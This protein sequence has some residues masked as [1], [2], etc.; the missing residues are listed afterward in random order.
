MVEI[1]KRNVY[2]RRNE[3][4]K[5]GCGNY[6]FPS[7]EKYIELVARRDLYKLLDEGLED[8]ANGRTQEF[9]VAMKEIRKH[10]ADGGK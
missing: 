8:I 9:S 4:A 2:R 5:H 10:I 6:I 1:V 3:S 7:V